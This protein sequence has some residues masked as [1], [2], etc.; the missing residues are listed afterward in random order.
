MQRQSDGAERTS[1][2]ECRSMEL[3]IMSLVVHNSNMSCG[4]LPETCN[5]N[6]DE[7]VEKFGNGAAHMEPGLIQIVTSVHLTVPKLSTCI[8]TNSDK[9]KSFKVC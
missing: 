5:T 8:R 9:Y 6:F 4:T 3:I 1:K 7:F 2:L